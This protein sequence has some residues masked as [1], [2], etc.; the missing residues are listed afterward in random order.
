[1]GAAGSRRER[2]R[3]CGTTLCQA[4]S[5]RHQDAG[6]WDMISGAWGFSESL[7]HRGTTSAW[8]LHFST[9]CFPFLSYHQ[10]EFTA[11]FPKTFSEILEV[12]RCNQK[13]LHRWSW[14]TS[15]GTGTEP[16]FV[17]PLLLSCGSLASCYGVASVQKSLGKWGAALQFKPC[18]CIWREENK[19]QSCLCS[20]PVTGGPE[21]LGAHIL[22]NGILSNGKELQGVSGEGKKPHLVV[23]FLCSGVISWLL[24]F[25]MPGSI[26]RSQ[27]ALPPVSFTAL[28]L[29]THSLI[30][31]FPSILYTFS[32][33]HKLMLEITKG[34]AKPS[35]RVSHHYKPLS[36]SC[37][38]SYF[39]GRYFSHL[40]VE[41]LENFIKNKEDGCP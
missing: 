35:P 12:S 22:L 41:N 8:F 24:L 32:S 16:C 33:W 26:L 21:Q 3:C 31:P 13:C 25:L 39:P 23:H 15:R 27:P 34:K 38:P 7:C 29:S 10:A 28:V 19:P 9:P 40:S 2:L 20:G 18:P 4:A 37:M 1:M 17:Q 11:K 36:S 6:V 30:H 5:G 14:G